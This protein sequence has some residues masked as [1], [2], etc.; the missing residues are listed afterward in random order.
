MLRV[1]LVERLEKWEDIKNFS[2]L[3]F[4]LVGMENWKNKKLFYLVE[5]RN[6]TIKN[7]DYINLL[8]YFNFNY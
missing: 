3:L 7:V 8:F 4:C 6:R 5:K 2:F 1:Y